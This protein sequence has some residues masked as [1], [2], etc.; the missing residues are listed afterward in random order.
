[1]VRMICGMSIAEIPSGCRGEE[2]AEWKERVEKEENFES[3]MNVV[4]GLPRIRAVGKKGVR[5]SLDGLAG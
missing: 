4:W 2:V 1:M 3:R 5:C